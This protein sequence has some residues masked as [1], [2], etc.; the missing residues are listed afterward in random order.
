MCGGK[1]VDS[2]DLHQ[3][4]GVETSHPFS[5]KKRTAGKGPTIPRFESDVRI[6]AISHGF[7]P[8]NENTDWAY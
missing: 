7:L 5:C 8:G 2:L 4:L 6:W 1:L 3:I